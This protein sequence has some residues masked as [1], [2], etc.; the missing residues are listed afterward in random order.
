M[1]L[2]RGDPETSILLVPLVQKVVSKRV[3]LK[4]FPQEAQLEDD[5]T[6]ATAAECIKSTLDLTPNKQYC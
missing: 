4:F 6:I 1:I 5:A 3:L 2:R